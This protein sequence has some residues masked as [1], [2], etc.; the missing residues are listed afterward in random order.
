MA[1]T[2]KSVAFYVVVGCLLLISVSFFLAIIWQSSFEYGYISLPFLNGAFV[3]SLWLFLPACLSLV[4]FGWTVVKAIK[5]SHNKRSF[6]LAVAFGFT[7]IVFCFLLSLKLVYVSTSSD[8]KNFDKPFLYYRIILVTILLFIVL[9][10]SILFYKQ[11][12][13]IK[14]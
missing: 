6:A 2:K 13:L 7:A 3:F 14:D 1:Q 5:F 11:K 9:L 4:L 10:L 8:N 12:K